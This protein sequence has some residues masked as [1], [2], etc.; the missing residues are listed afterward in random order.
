MSVKTLTK[1]W[2]K[3]NLKKMGKEERADFVYEEIP[4]VID[5]Y[6]KKGWR[7]DSKPTVDAIFDI[8]EDAK[9]LKTLKY[10]AKNKE[11]YTL[12]LGLAVV[13]NDFLGH[14]ISKLDEDM[15]S[16]YTKLI[17][18]ILKPRVKQ[19]TKKIDIDPELLR[20]FLVI[21]PDPELV[22]D[23][24]VVSIY[25]GRMLNKIYTLAGEEPIDIDP[26][27]LKKLFKHIFGEEALTR[28]AVGALLQRKD[29][30]SKFNTEAQLKLWNN[31]TTFALNTLEKA[32]KDE[33][34][35][36]LEFYYRTCKKDKDRGNNFAR[37]TELTT[38]GED[39]PNIYKTLCKL[40]VVTKS[41]DK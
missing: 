2:T 1:T 12:D 30:L 7:Q 4:S 16:G 6:V 29:T 26:K 38:L 17:C 28:I 9:F 37:R 35:Q 19:I 33:L 36:R 10:I 31:V 8:M 3:K 39:Y 34:R 40:G 18:K 32:D 23:K 24:K 14:R 11:E 27:T 20:E 5:F 21:T 41:K 22:S 25:S 15:V 13:I